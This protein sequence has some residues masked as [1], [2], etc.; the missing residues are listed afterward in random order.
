MANEIEILAKI[1]I[2]EWVETLD[3]EPGSEFS[4]YSI[5]PSAIYNKIKKL[6][7]Q[8]DNLY[9]QREKNKGTELGGVG[10]YTKQYNSDDEESSRW[11]G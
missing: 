6:K 10:D 1:E 9:K 3:L 8:L 7:K 4:N 2:L 11:G 5:S